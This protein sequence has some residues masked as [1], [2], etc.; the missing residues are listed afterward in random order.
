MDSLFELKKKYKLLEKK[1]LA[2][3]FTESDL[4]IK[5][6][7]GKK[8]YHIEYQIRKTSWRGPYEVWKMLLK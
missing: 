7:I 4:K 8:I 5:D 1:K 6:E 3:T 2:G